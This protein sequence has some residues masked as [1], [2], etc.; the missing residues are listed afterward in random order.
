MD[1]CAVSMANGL[2][3]SKMKVPKILLIALMFGVFQGGMPLI[4]YFIGS[5]TLNKISWSIPYLALGLLSIIGI[6]MILD[7]VKK[8]EDINEESL[9]FKVILLQ[10]IATSIDALTVGFTISNYLLLEALISVL[11]ISV[12]T[13]VVCFIGVLIGKKFG[14]TL[15]NKSQ[16]FG[17]VILLIIGVEIFLKG[18]FL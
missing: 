11:M 13:V 9:T 1:A 5:A 7:G 4:G 16:I 2:K 3:E 10:A 18:V 8:E 14:I 15:G 17:G 6:R 12:I